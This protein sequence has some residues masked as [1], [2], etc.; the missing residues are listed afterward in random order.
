MGV[1][2]DA[3]GRELYYWNDADY[4]CVY[5]D[6]AHTQKVCY[7]SEGKIYRADSSHTS[8]MTRYSE[9]TGTVQNCF[10]V[11]CIDTSNKKVYSKDSVIHETLASFT[12]NTY[13]A[14]AAAACAFLLP[15][16]EKI[17][18]SPRRRW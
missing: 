18:N 14:A 8:T 10:G 11:Y 4:G 16:E 13:G 12:G 1:L 7:Y 5:A 17:R 15:L 6:A 9:F 3:S 2:K